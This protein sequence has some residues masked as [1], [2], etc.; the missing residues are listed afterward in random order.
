MSTREERLELALL[1]VADRVKVEADAGAP[2]C[3]IAVY[4]RI[5]VMHALS[6]HDGPAQDCEPCYGALAGW[7]WGKPARPTATHVTVNASG[8]MKL[9]NDDGR[10]IV[11]ELRRM[12]RLGPNDGMASA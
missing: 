1:Q 6:D 8:G 12:R 2:G 4:T 11:R 3:M 9:T 5:E 10:E 7:G